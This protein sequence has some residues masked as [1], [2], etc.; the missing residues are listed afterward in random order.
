[1][2]LD[3]QGPT[4]S[5]SKDA[6]AGLL[7]RLGCGADALVVPPP[8]RGHKQQSESKKER[9]R[10]PPANPLASEALLTMRR[11]FSTGNFGLALGLILA[12]V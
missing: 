4:K 2:A 7:A 1:M 9:M 5:A 10:S 6:S 3:Y 12:C 11:L 8:A